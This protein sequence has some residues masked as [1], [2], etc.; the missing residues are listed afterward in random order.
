MNNSD[1]PKKP[2]RYGITPAA[3]IEIGW[4]IFFVAGLLGLGLD[5]LI[6][7]LFG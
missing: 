2:I 3:F 6:E 7:W 1:D 4:L 5:R